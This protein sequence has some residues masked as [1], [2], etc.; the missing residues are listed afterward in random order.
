MRS[1]PL[2]ASPKRR[3][4]PRR[5]LPLARFLVPGGAGLV[6]ALCGTGF[7]YWTRVTLFKQAHFAPD[8]AHPYDFYATGCLM[9]GMLALATLLLSLREPPPM[10][11]RRPRRAS[12]SRALLPRTPRPKS[13][14]IGPL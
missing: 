13:G 1:L 4:R 3:R 2:L 8:S 12:R 7:V 14:T 5:S 10:R 11:W 6:L 9:A